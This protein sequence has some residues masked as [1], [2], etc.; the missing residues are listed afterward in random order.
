MNALHDKETTTIFG[1]LP[2]DV[3]TISTCRVAST[4][5][6]SSTTSYRESSLIGDAAEVKHY[7]SSV[8]SE[9]DRISIDIGD[10][11]IDMD[12]E[13]DE[14]ASDTINVDDYGDAAHANNDAA[15]GQG[16]HID[17]K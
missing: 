12:D 3:Y 11:D 15:I 13:D 7:P 4:V 6:T 14:S 8:G 17:L 16:F 1:C 5:T 2:Q 10:S 9:P